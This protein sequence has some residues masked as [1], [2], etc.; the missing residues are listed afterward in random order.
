V[1]AGFLEDVRAAGA[2]VSTMCKRYT[3]MWENAPR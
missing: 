2:R 3:I 1:S